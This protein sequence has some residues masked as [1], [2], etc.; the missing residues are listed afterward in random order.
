MNTTVSEENKNQ[1]IW[2]PNREGVRFKEFLELKKKD[3]FNIDQKEIS[4]QA[5]L[6]LSS[7]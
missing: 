5:S 6:I 7:A 4:D 1:K 3:S 2:E